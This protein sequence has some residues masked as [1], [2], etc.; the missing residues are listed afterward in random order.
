VLRGQSPFT[1]DRAHIH[2]RL[3]SVGLGTRATMLLMTGVGALVGAM[4]VALVAAFG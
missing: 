3:Q 4:A 2:H 1:A